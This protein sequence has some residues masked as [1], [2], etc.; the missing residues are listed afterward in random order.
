MCADDDAND[1]KQWT[2]HEWKHNETDDCI[3][4]T[5][6]IAQLIETTKQQNNKI[7]DDDDDD[8]DDDNSFCDH[9]FPRKTE[10]GNQKKKVR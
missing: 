10:R 2:P 5:P 1:D 4:F 9:S 3:F 8:D 6:I 7:Y